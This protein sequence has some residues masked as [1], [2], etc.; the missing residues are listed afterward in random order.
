MQGLSVVL[1]VVY[2]L[3]WK[4]GKHLLKLGV[5]YAGV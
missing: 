4:V 3:G 1:A 2:L 5:G